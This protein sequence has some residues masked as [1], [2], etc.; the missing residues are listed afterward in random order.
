MVGNKALRC[1]QLV[2]TGY[3]IYKSS[4]FGSAFARGLPLQIFKN[5][6]CYKQEITD[7]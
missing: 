2:A 7:A 5:A 6:Q 4:I 1:V 3:G